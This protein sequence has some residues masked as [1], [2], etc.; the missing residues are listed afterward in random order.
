[1]EKPLNKTMEIV[2]GLL[3]PSVQLLSDS[4]DKAKQL[5]AGTLA[6]YVA[7]FDDI[8][9]AMNSDKHKVALFEHGITPQIFY[10]FDCAPLCLEVFPGLFASTSIDTVYEFL[11]AADEAGLPSEVCSTD[12]FLLGATLRGEMPDNSFFV[13][14]TS[15]CDGTRLAYPIMQKIAKSPLCYIET[16]FSHN[17]DAARFFGGQIKAQLIPFLEK[18]T[19]IKF[20]IDKFR[21]IIEESN[22]ALE[23]LIDI[24][25]TYTVKPAPHRAAL[26]QAPWQGFIMQAGHPRLTDSLE[27]LKED[28]V[29]RVKNSNPESKYDEK[30]RIL[31]LHVPPAFNTRLFGWMEKKLGACV[32]TNFC[33]LIPDPIDTTSLDTMIEGYAMQGLTMT[34]SIMRIDSAELVRQAMANF[35][36]YNCD[37]MIITQHVGCNSICGARG[38]MREYLRKENIP[39]LFL[40]FDYNDDRVLSAEAMQEQIEDFFETVMN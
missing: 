26:R 40:E 1:M 28:A 23:L 24:H 21:E 19:G 10:A 9:E 25:E 14:T 38:I 15:P 3:K 18:V 34:M 7:I 11:A 13:T 29:L 37:C 12:R 36:T 31:W 20:D 39:A 35:N 8:V 22:K 32:L 30:Y 17:R 5:R 4:G 2:D 27:S 16:P 33:C 6:N